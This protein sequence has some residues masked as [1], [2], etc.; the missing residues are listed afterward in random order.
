MKKIGV[1]GLSEGNGHPYSWSAIFNGYDTFHMANC[2]FP[3]IPNYLSKQIFPNDFL[4]DLGQVTHIWTQDKSISIN[5]AKASLIDNISNSIDDMID[6]VDVV[7]LAR[8]DAENHFVHSKSIIEAGKPIFI[9]KPFALNTDVAIKMLGSQKYESQIFTCTSLR[10]SEE[11]YLNEHDR[12]SIGDIVGFE[13]SIMNKWEK[14]AI[15]LIEPIIV[16]NP[17]RGLLL[18]VI[19]VKKNDEIQKTIIEWE[20][21]TGNIINTGSVPVALKISYIGKKGIV[22][23]QFNDSF[24]C[25]KSSLK[26]FIDVI[27][28]KKPNIQRNETLEIV[29]ILEKGIA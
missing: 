15:H 17:N 16:Q 10:F 4:N 19:P 6:E 14:Y 11:L 13:A 27:D 24:K 1:I 22:T 3:V 7:L 5:I 12:E 25:F 2:P 29:K 26:Y 23:K 8:D 28:G 20:N 9:D 21:L 18:R